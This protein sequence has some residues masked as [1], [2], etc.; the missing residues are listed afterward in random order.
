MEG[1][2][3]EEPAKQENNNSFFADTRIPEKQNGVAEINVNVNVINTPDLSPVKNIRNGDVE[4]P[5][6]R[7]TKVTYNLKSDAN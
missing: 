7:K 3:Q 2:K 1:A 6:I 4:D 5:E